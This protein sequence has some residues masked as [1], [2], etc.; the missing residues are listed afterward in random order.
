MP[1]AQWAGTDTNELR[2]FTSSGP[3]TIA[4]VSTAVRRLRIVSIAAIPAPMTANTIT[5]TKRPEIAIGLGNRGIA[6]GADAVGHQHVRDPLIVVR[7]D[8][9]EARQQARRRS[10]DRRPVPATHIQGIA[11]RSP[12]HDLFNRMERRAHLGKG[13]GDARLEDGAREPA[14]AGLPHLADDRNQGKQRQQQR[15]RLD[16]FQDATASRRQRPSPPHLET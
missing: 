10:L 16:G 6:D 15:G 14:Q 13:F 11:L 9:R 7:G 2:M 1:N 3:Y 4:S 12:S 5:D 8:A